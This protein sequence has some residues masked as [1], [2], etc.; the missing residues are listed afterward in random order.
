MIY[1]NHEYSKFEYYDI[2]Q[3]AGKNEKPAFGQNKV[4]A[5]VFRGFFGGF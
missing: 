3:L 5:D 2:I 1:S 4:R